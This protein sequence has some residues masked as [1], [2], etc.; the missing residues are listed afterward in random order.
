MLAI[1]LFNWQMDYKKYRKHELPICY[2]RP[3]KD[4]SEEIVI[5][6]YE[7]TH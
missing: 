5:N 3:A 7:L 4:V 6:T 1:T 2:V